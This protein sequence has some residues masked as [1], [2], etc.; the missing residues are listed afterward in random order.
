MKLGKRKIG[1]L[2]VIILSIMTVFFCVIIL[3]EESAKVEKEILLNEICSNNFSV[4]KNE[5]GK[6]CDYIEIYNS[7][8]QD[9]LLD[10]YYISDDKQ[11]LCKYSLQGKMVPAKG[12]LVIW[13]DNVIGEEEQNTV[14]KISAEG[15]SVYLVKEEKEEIVDSVYV[16]KLT[17]N[18]SYGRIAED[19]KVWN[20]MQPSLGCSNAGAEFLPAVELREPQFSVESGFYEE[21]F[22]LS[23]R[24]GLGEEIYYTLDGS[25]PTNRSIKYTGKIKIGDASDEANVYASRKDLSPTRDYAPDFNVDKATV[26]RAISY[27]TASNK[28]SDVVT[29]VYFIGYENRAEYNDFPVVSLVADGEDLFGYENGIY[30]NG[31]TLDEYKESGGI[32][33][34]QLLGHFV[35][36]SGRV[37]NLYEATNA[38][39]EGKE[40]ERKANFTY[41]N[42][43]HK[44]EFS[45]EVGIRI[46]GASTRGT[47]QKSISV[48]GRDIYDTQVV[49]PIEFFEGIKGTTV[50]L[51]N[52]G[53]HNDGVKI[54]DAFVESLIEDR[55]VSIQRSTPTILFL[56]GEYWGIYN[57]RERYNEEYVSTHYGICEDNVWIIDGGRAKAGGSEASEAYD[58]FV[59]M[60]TECD[61]SYDDV[62]AMVSELIDV[63]SFIDYCCINI[64]MD[65]QDLSFGQNMALWRS[66]TND[67]SK[68]GDAKWRWMV[69][70]MDEAIQPYDETTDP[71]D[72]M[73]SFCLMQEP[74]LQS[75]MRNEGFREQFFAT[76]L[77]I[78]RNNY[79]YE[80]VNAKLKEWKTIYEEQL[81]INHQRFFNEGYDRNA[82]EQDFVFMDDFFARRYEFI[83]RA[84]EEIKADNSGGG[85]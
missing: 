34:G 73:K 46:A 14:L 44:Y 69:F 22:K 23:I 29:K 18:T 66:A 43:E 62:Y 28:V 38:F 15:E 49:F 4:G 83:K 11:F 37:Y 35:D 79:G 67:G 54:K 74:I 9:K 41:F 19:Q 64:Y 8:E 63:Q 3:Y 85:W 84:V 20:I 80:E 6:Y 45:Q 31:K 78:G 60:A 27:N 58:Y 32:Q 26:V 12:Y 2:W 24:A 81:L 5:L 36:E 65:N 70:D 33:D 48:Y 13:L 17:Y 10:G 51:R 39:K 25:E 77:E 42:A 47:P 16:P 72:W 61:L 71:G 68:Y 21:G 57:L 1:I 82:L 50:K 76:L 7:T 52:G 40:W 53:N 30:G 55:D 75:F 59:T 56:N